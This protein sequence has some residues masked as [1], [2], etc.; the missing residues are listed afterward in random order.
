MNTLKQFKYVTLEKLCHHESYKYN[1]S[2][3]IEELIKEIC[4]WDYIGE[5]HLSSEVLTELFE[6]SVNEL[7]S[8]EII[9]KCENYLYSKRDRLEEEIKKVAISLW[10]DMNGNF[11]DTTEIYNMMWTEDNFI[12]NESDIYGIAGIVINSGE[13]DKYIISKLDI[14][15]T[16]WGERNEFQVVSDE[17]F[18]N[19][20]GD[21]YIYSTYD[22]M[23]IDDGELVDD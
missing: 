6:E 19:Y 18:T 14:I 9:N 2:M 5:N 21:C 15:G 23:W 8:E 22:E 13:A 7:C 4:K 10:E 11:I 1:E 3:K 17:Y 20:W 12:L 16:I